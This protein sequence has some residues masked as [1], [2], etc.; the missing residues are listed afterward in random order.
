MEFKFREGQLVRRL[1]DS[2]GK[3]WGFDDAD[4]RYELQIVEKK[5]QR[6]TRFPRPGGRREVKIDLKDKL[7]NVEWVTFE[8]YYSPG[9]LDTDEEDTSVIEHDRRFPCAV[10][11]YTVGEGAEGTDLIKMWRLDTALYIE[12]YDIPVKTDD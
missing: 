9:Y 4:N 7:G 1:I 2:T 11:R 12:V 8:Q 6:S 3:P 10:R 5:D